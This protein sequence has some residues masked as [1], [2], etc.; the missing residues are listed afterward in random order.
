MLTVCFFVTEC[1]IGKTCA[2]KVLFVKCSPQSRLWSIPCG[3]LSNLL[4]KLQSISFSF[5]LVAS[6]VYMYILYMYMYMYMWVAF[7][8]AHCTFNVVGVFILCV[9][10]CGIIAKLCCWPAISYMHVDMWMVTPW[11]VRNQPLKCCWNHF[12]F[13]VHGT[14]CNL[15]WVQYSVLFVFISDRGKWVLLN[16]CS[17]SNNPP[18]SYSGFVLSGHT[19]IFSFFHLQKRTLIARSWSTKVGVVCIVDITT[20]IKRMR[21]DFP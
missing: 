18:I 9:S 19:F 7:G 4:Y 5:K 2:A 17:S 10:F 16:W 12:P 3:L 20:K 11:Q 15:I 21:S 14:S 6:A 1:D 8:N 13:R